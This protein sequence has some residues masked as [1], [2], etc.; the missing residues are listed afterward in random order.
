[1]D[2]NS[3]LGW[4]RGANKEAADY[5]LQNDGQIQLNPFQRLFGATE[6]DVQNIINT[7]QQKANNRALGAAAIEAGLTPY[8]GG[9]LSDYGESSSAFAARIKKAKTAK[10]NAKE[11]KLRGYAV[12]DATRAQ[13][14]AMALG[15][16]TIDANAASLEAQIQASAQEGQLARDSAKDQY[17]HSSN[18]QENRYAHER[19]EGRLDR[20][21]QM[22][23][24]MLNGNHQMAIAEMNSELA[25]KRM[26]FDRE[27]QRLDKRDRMIAQLM[28]GLGSLGGAMSL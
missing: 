26:D 4:D 14:N 22:E 2:I 25:D 7:R 19:A 1:M 10:E 11:A 21:Q 5:A 6:K 12:E 16:Q 13:N 23:L 27:T 20:R 17:L 15:K 3:I 8:A 18:M 24:A 28:S 9:N